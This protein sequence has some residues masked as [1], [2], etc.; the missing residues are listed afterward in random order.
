MRSS[1]VVASAAAAAA[2]QIAGSGLAGAALPRQVHAARETAAVPLAPGVQKTTV[3][4]GLTGPGIAAE[5]DPK[6]YNFVWRAAPGDRRGVLLVFLGGST[7]VPSYYQ[8]IGA[9]A[10]NDGVDAIDLRYPDAKIVGAT[11][12][13]PAGGETQDACFSSFR[14]TTLFGAGSTYGRPTGTW[15][16]PENPVSLP[17]SVVNRLVRLLAY[18]HWGQYLRRSAASPYGGML[19]RW[20][21]IVVAGHS[22]GGGDAAFL[23]TRVAVRRLVAFSSPDDTDT[24][25]T[26]SPHPASWITDP[27]ATPPERFYGLRSTGEGI[28]G[29]GTA[30]NWIALRFPGSPVDID[31]TPAPFGR[32]HQLV[33]SLRPRRCLALLVCTALDYHSSTV[34]DAYTPLTAQGVPVFSPVWTYLLVGSGS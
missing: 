9:T 8:D 23:A 14:G 27:S 20:S 24:R 18:L 16:S 19:P 13:A 34:V 12:V 28:Y 32:S 29:A 30:T 7:T 1:W 17:D 22:Q 2:T 11:C 4:P 15:S 10:A 26:T 21:G 33:T 5:S 3:Q 6:A 25:G 31:T